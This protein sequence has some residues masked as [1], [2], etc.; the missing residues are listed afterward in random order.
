MKRKQAVF[1]VPDM[2]CS[3]CAERVQSVLG[4][5]EGVQSASADLE[6]KTAT[7]DYDADTTTPDAILEAIEEAG[8]SPTRT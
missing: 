5:L 6:A 3:G 7:A 1:D 8:Y 4:R 2:K